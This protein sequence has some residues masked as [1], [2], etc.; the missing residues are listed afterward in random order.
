[1]F[2][3]WIVVTMSCSAMAIGC[4]GEPDTNQ[5]IIENLVSSDGR[6]AAP[7]HFVATAMTHSVRLSWD[8]SIGATNYHIWSGSASLGLGCRQRDDIC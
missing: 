1:M 3:K 5:E 7:M 4:A 2:A 8:P 6:P